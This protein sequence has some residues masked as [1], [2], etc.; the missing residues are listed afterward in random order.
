MGSTVEHAGHQ[1][2]HS[3]ALKRGARLGLVAYGIVHLLIAWI[4]LQ[5]AWSGGGEASSDGALR[6]LAGQPFGQAVLWVTAVSL[7]TLVLWQVATA[8]SGHQSEDG[9]KRTRRRLAAAGRAVVYAVLAF[10]AVRIATGS[11]GGSGSDSA[12]EGLTAELLSAPAGRVLVVIIAVV[13]LAVA[14]RQVHRGL[15]DSFTH[16]LEVG[17]ST[18]QSGSLV[19][20]VGRVGYV[21]K[22]VA[23]GVVGVLFGWAAISYDPDKAGG[24]DD[25]LKTVRDQPFGP[26]LLTVVALG[27]AAFGLYCFAWAR[28]ARTR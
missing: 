22:G 12:E 10:S 8:V 2:R 27:L 16:D 9:F 15:T 19:L 25:A 24:L 26:Y 28:H 6:K 18:G 11:G 7:V 1:A 21:A 13:I 17:A 3:E 23:I 5:V 14:A 20:V 4:A